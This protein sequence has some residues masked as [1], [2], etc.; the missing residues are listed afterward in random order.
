[1]EDDCL[2]TTKDGVKV[3]C[4]ARTVGAGTVELQL[5][6]DYLHLSVSEYRTLLKM[7]CRFDEALGADHSVK[8]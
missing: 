2:I 4:T 1:M 7:L 8:V 3:D 6:R 5:G